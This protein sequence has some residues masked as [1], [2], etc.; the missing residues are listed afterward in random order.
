MEGSLVA[1]K[2]FTNGS[3][4]N[5]SEVNDNLM[6]QAVITF[7]NSTA[8]ASAITSPVE[9]MVT[10]LADTNTYQF[11]NGSAWTNLV[12][13]SSGLEFI[14]RTTASAVASV[15][16]NDI[17]STTY[18]N[19]RIV[20]A[21]NA[22]TA[23]D[24]TMRMRVGGADNTTSNYNSQRFSVR[25]NS[26]NFASGATNQTSFN[27]FL[28]VNSAEANGVSLDIYSPFLASPT[29]YSSL[30]HL[31]DPTSLFTSMGGGVHFVASSFTGLTFTT[32]TGN[33]TATIDVYGYRKA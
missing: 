20:I 1:Y 24:L 12:S 22:S 25:P 19:Y 16:L 9:G 18:D 14:G 3:V 8:R 10:Y 30:A 28:T 5:A 11:W 21:P 15:S 27:N 6:N 32:T 29:K 31:H 13:S 7:T 2:V 26:A 33:L 4:L 17:F 23:F